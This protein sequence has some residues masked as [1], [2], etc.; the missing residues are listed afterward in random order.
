MDDQGQHQVL[1]LGEN[2]RL[3]RILGARQQ[4][5]VKRVSSSAELLKE[6]KAFF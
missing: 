1:L 6:L 3:Q 4:L 2:K 5:C